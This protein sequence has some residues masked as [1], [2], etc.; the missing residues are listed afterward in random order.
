MIGAFIICFAL[1]AN[2]CQGGKW[3]IPFAV[4]NRA[5][6]GVRGA[7]FVVANRL[8]LSFCWYGVQTWWGGQVTKNMIGAIWPQF[9]KMHNHFPESAAMKTNDFSTSPLAPPPCRHCLI[10]LTPTS[11]A[12]FRILVGFIIFWT[13]SL[14]IL[15]IKP[16]RYRI[17]AVISSVYCSISVIALLIWALA[18]QKGG[19]PLLYDTQLT[20]G[21]PPL[22]GSAL[23]W[24]MARSVTTTVGGWAGAVSSLLLLLLSRTRRTSRSVSRRC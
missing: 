14:P 20:T 13:I 5:P 3:H 6:W 9:Y 16:E 21:V 19:G 8:I 24:A 22:K 1:V 18:K 17:P 15:A 4:G 12:L 10:S 7:W 2:G 11:N 23:G